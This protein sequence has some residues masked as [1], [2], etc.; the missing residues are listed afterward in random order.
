ML[1]LK[2]TLEKYKTSEL[3]GGFYVK[4]SKVYN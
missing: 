4:E 2:W 1:P 3:Q